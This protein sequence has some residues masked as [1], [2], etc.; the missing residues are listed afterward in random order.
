MIKEERKEWEKEERIKKSP[1]I[2]GMIKGERKGW[3][4]EGRK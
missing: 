1:K 4:K 3:D 2:T